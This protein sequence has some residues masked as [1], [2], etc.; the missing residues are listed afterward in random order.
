[1]NFIP[2][3]AEQCTSNAEGCDEFTNLDKKELEGESKE[4]YTQIRICIKPDSSCDDFYA[5]E[6]S[7]ESGFQLKAFSLEKSTTIE[8]PIVTNA[9]KDAAECSEAIFLLPPSDPLYNP[10]CREFYSK[11]GEKS[12]HL[13]SLTI[14]CSEDCHPFR[15]SENNYDPSITMASC[16]G[17]DMSWDASESAC[18]Y[19]INGGVWSTEHE[20]CIYNGIPGDGKTCSSNV[21]GCRQYTGNYGN[22]MQTILSNDFEDGTAQGWAKG[23]ATIVSNSNVSL[24]VSGH[25]LSV[26]GS[27][28]IASTTVF[29]S[30]N[31]SYVLS[32]IV[33]STVAG[34]AVVKAYF[35]DGVSSADFSATTSADSEWQFYKINLEDT[36]ENIYT[37]LAIEGTAAFYVDSI[38]LVRITNRYFLIKGSWDTPLSCDNKADDPFG[39]ACPAKENRCDI[40]EMLKCS[41]YYDRD[42]TDHTLRSFSQLCQESAV[43][44]ELLIDTHNS[45]SPYEQTL[46][47][48]SIN[49][50]VTI[51][52]D[53]PAYVVYSKNHTCAS[54]DK[55]CQR[56]GSPTVFG[57][58]RLFDD[59][60]IEN[61]PDDYDNTLCS[62]SSEGCEENTASAGTSYFIEPGDYACEYRSGTDGTVAWWQK[63]VSRCDDGSGGGAIDGTINKSKETKYCRS[64]EDCGNSGGTCTSDSDCPV[65]QKCITGLCNYECVKDENEYDCPTSDLLTFGTGATEVL[66]PESGYAG[67]CPASEA[68]CTEY[69]DPLSG[70]SS[71]FLFNNTL[72][73]IDGDSV[74]YDGWTLS[75]DYYQDTTVD[76][77]TLYVLSVSGAGNGWAECKTSG[78]T[79]YELL[80]TNE[81]GTAAAI[82]SKVAA[83]SL[84]FYSG[85]CDA[86]RVWVS[87]GVTEINL[88]RAIIDYQLSKGVD[89]TTCAGTMGLNDGCILFNER[90]VSTSTTYASL[91]YD[92]DNSLVPGKFPTLC[93]GVGC[94]SN[95][96]I[97][98]SPTRTCDKWLACKS[99]VEIKNKDGE[100]E[101]V[102]YDIGLC[103]GLDS[104]DNCSSYPIIN[105]DEQKASPGNYAKFANNSGYSKIGYAN[106]TK[107]DMKGMYPLS[108]MS[109]IGE[110]IE[111][112]NGNFEYYSSE[113]FP[114]GW[115][116]NDSAAWQLKMFSV[117]NNPYQA[118][119]EGVRYLVDGHAFLKF[120]PSSGGNIR[121]EIISVEPNSEYTLTYYS[122][123]I[124]LSAGG[125]AG[126]YI[127]T[128]DSN[129][130]EVGH[131][132]YGGTRDIDYCY[133]PALLP[134]PWISGCH[135]LSYPGRDWTKN[136]IRFKVGAN[137]R[138]L[139]LHIW[140]GGTGNAY[141]DQVSLKPALENRSNSIIP[142]TCRLYPESDSLSCDYYDSSAIRQKGWPGYCLEYD[143]YPG[144]PKNCLMWWPVDRVK[145]DG[146]D[147][148]AGYS[149]KYPVYYCGGFKAGILVEAREAYSMTPMCRSTGDP[150][151]EPGGDELT[152][153]SGCGCTGDPGNDPSG[154]TY[155]IIA[156]GPSCSGSGQ[157]GHYY[158]M[159]IDDPMLVSEGEKTI[160][161]IMETCNHILPVTVEA[162]TN[163][164]LALSYGF[165][166]ILSEAK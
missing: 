30:E 50:Q 53:N 92:A 83:N 11:T 147:E 140:G 39:E 99:K 153:C 115:S 80:G 131:S 10:D 75:G 4:Y 61:N 7:D 129:G 5:W 124:N 1:M 90:T 142:Q 69:I 110:N 120:S 48:G 86:I 91:D 114:I 162:G 12:Y 107:E 155:N 8:E 9:V 104:N 117:V 134:T 52:S 128:M 60:Y 118:Q 121:T 164:R 108:K 24:Q 35:T 68:T 32:F 112:P 152:S 98:V 156:P 144:D 143:R 141:F 62:S 23:P 103:N 88:R 122:N 36:G 125:A 132:I 65:N 26:Q 84:H 133:A 96:V 14:S 40:G 87:A 25:S 58:Q 100:K 19:C 109:Q 73:D 146:L 70:F 20:A 149:G 105:K 79:V 21:S 41:R 82:T 137:T 72:G 27:P 46:P 71:S 2:S 64:D 102:C 160:M 89:K 130:A 111:V 42:K 31:S 47:G 29:T 116:K 150:C 44:C 94:D 119:Q 154:Y 54:A 123:T 16:V 85:D 95:N 78:K 18:I 77:N 13:Y 45:Q 28:G 67:L 139:V 145:G 166:K 138:S 126:V 74:F 22:N 6:G 135:Y 37:R 76:Y 113:K 159:S 38:K 33:K 43:G 15:K 151:A 136:S 157:Q 93:S 63:S 161:R 81:L 51:A 3:T 56:M 66:Q 158:I 106:T 55:G 127:T 163:Q 165:L 148:G 49:P 97:K 17:A 101:N 34:G 59:S 57:P